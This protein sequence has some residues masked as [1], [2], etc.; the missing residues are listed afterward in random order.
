MSAKNNWGVCATHC[1]YAVLASV[2][3]FRHSGT[4]HSVSRSLCLLPIRPDTQ[5][6]G[7]GKDATDMPAGS[8]SLRWALLLSRMTRSPSFGNS[9]GFVTP[10]YHTLVQVPITKEAPPQRRGLGGA[11]ILTA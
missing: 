10:F 6:G 11:V 3:G 2:P 1:A 5:R 4:G 8:R 7:T 9:C